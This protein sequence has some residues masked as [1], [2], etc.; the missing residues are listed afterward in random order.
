M[1][2]LRKKVE[3]WG[4]LETAIVFIF[5][6]NLGGDEIGRG[7]KKTKEQKTEKTICFLGEN[8]LNFVRKEMKIEED[9]G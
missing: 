8:R 9:R 3:E 1:N 2:F 4:S 6:T 7:K 5:K